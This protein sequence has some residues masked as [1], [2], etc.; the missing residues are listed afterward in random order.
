M[1]AYSNG[2]GVGKWERIGEAHL[3]YDASAYNLR[4]AFQSQTNVAKILHNKS[5]LVLI[6]YRN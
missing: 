4:E 1:A 3:R 5:H 2:T 6:Y